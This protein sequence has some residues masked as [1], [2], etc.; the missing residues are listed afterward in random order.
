MRLFM[1]IHHSNGNFSTIGFAS[2]IDEQNAVSAAGVQ[3]AAMS[4]S[5]YFSTQ[6]VHSVVLVDMV[7]Q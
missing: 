6:V 4:L 2:A 7:R 3:F 5:L 1:C